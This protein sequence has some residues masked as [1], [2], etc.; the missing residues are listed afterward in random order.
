MGRPMAPRA[1]LMKWSKSTFFW[2]SNPAVKI[3][4]RFHKRH[5]DLATELRLIWMGTAWL[6]PPAAPEIAA[7]GHSGA[8]RGTAGE[9]TDAPGGL[10]R[11]E[12]P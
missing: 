10:I 4:A 9:L 7:P 11:I 1:G 6:N 12:I 5:G 3:P 2:P 8:E